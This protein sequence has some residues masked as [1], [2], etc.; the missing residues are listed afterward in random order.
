M[1]VKLKFTAA[2]DAIIQRPIQEDFEG[3]SELTPFIMQGDARFFNLE[4]TLNREG[5]AYGSQFSGG[6]YIRA[7][8]EV[9][10]GMMELGFNMTSFNNNHVLDFGY[11]GMLATLNYVEESGLV[12]AGVGEN[13]AAASAPRYL[14]TKNGRVALIAVNTS[15]HA[16]AMA[17]IQTGRV[18]GRPGINGIRIEEKFTVTKEELAFIREL[19]TRMRVNVSREIVRREGY[20]PPLADDMAEFGELKFKL[21]E[22]T[23]RTLVANKA[24]MARLEKSIYEAKMQADYVMVSIHSHQID[25]N[26]KEDVPAFLSEIAHAAIDMGANAVVGHGPHLLRPIEVYKDSPIFYSLGDFVLELYSIEFAPSDFFEKQDLDGNETV[27]ALLKKRSQGF[28]VGLME[29]KKMMEAVIP[30]W[31]TEDGKLTALRLMPVELKKGGHKS[32]EGLPRRASDL[33]FMDRLADMCRPLGVS[34][35]KDADG[36][37]TCRW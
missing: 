9:L 4:T 6:T 31:E 3:F 17:G 35:E 16:T 30:Y 25:G 12:H 14:E 7:N 23:E 34:L 20:Y 11:P 8:P 27:H 15:F 37:Y 2:G 22:K 1:S 21:G 19:A 33:S 29:E 36:I 26:A 18:P 5:E 28:K 13:L 24:D 10:D 32:E